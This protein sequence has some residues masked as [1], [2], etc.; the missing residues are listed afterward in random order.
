MRVVLALVVSLLLS[1]VMEVSAVPLEKPAER[2][3]ES[4]IPSRLEPAIAAL[5]QGDAQ[6]ATKLAREF[7]KEQPASAR[8]HEVLGLAA[9]AQRRW[10][11]ADR[12]LS[13]AVKLDPGRVSAFLGLGKVALERKDPKRSEELFR[14]ALSVAPRAPEPHRALAL[15]LVAQGNLQGAI[16]AAERSLRLSGA[17]PDTEYM[18]A[19]LY[20]D[21]GRPDGAERRLASVL[22]A[23]PE[24]QAALLLQGLVKLELG[25][26]ERGGHPPRA[27]PASRSTHG[28]G[29]AGQGEP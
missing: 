6:T 26:P 12:A 9:I 27:G 21:A 24:S 18:L 29:E 22:A 1:P 4:S 3:A 7:L 19:G 5:Q 23:R 2:P 8:G 28:A 10:E 17:D 14:R 13:E 11:E 20:H 16:G 25:K 15:A